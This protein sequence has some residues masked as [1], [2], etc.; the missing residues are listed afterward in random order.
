MVEVSKI[1]KQKFKIS[2]VFRYRFLKIRQK[3][4]LQ[5]AMP[6]GRTFNFACIEVFKFWILSLMKS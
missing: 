5:C 6:F 2:K 3:A 4:A 1:K